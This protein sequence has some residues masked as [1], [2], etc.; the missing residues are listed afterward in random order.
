MTP[1]R[2]ALIDLPELHNPKVVVVGYAGRDL[3][4]VQHHIDELAAIGV[5]PPPEVPMLYPMP[6]ET[7]ER[8]AAIEVQGRGTS[9]EVEPVLVRA[10]SRWYLTIGSDHTDR[11]L[12]V[13][14]ILLSKQVCGKPIA[15]QAIALDGDPTDGAADALWDSAHMDSWVDGVPYQSG[16]LSTLRHPSDLI[17]R[18]TA[19]NDTTGDLVIFGGTVPLIDGTFRPG[20]VFTA[21]LAVPGVDSLHLAYTTTVS[22]EETD[23]QA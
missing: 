8:S 11:D 3:A 22:K 10:G 13:Q 1:P 20:Q 14:D 4:S 17:E 16:P 2:E 19:A 23:E 7:L 21:T 15:S 9:G 6:Q 12:E 18:V 5:A